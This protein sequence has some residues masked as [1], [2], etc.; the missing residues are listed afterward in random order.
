MTTGE[1]KPEQEESPIYNPRGVGRKYLTCTHGA[2]ARR[3]RGRLARPELGAGNVILSKI[4]SRISVIAIKDAWDS[5]PGPPGAFQSRWRHHDRRS[6]SMLVASGDCAGMGRQAWH[7][8][9]LDGVSPSP[10]GEGEDGMSV[11]HSGSLY[12]RR[13]R[14]WT[15]T[16]DS[17]GGRDW[18]KAGRQ[19]RDKTN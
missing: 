5:D 9:R 10:R 12:R 13:A 16:L 4:E 18:R 8:P 11:S 1:K 15:W 6:P 14:D 19:A 17:D 3:I 7:G 2:E